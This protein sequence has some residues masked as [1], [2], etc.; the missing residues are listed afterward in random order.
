MAA[1]DADIY[2]FHFLLRG[3]VD[4]V[5]LPYEDYRLL[6][7]RLN[8]SRARSHLRGAGIDAVLD[9]ISPLADSEEAS[10]LVAALPLWHFDFVDVIVDLEL[11]GID[12]IKGAPGLR[13]C[14]RIVAAPVVKT[15]RRHLA[16]LFLVSLA[17]IA[18]GFVEMGCGVGGCGACVCFGALIFLSVWATIW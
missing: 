4:E 14:Q 16:V 15:S 5:A 17:G 3:V 8:V 7:E 12:L 18:E 1:S 2:I 9:V 13:L 6:L 10:A 11:E